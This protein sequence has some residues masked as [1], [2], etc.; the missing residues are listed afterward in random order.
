MKIN[1]K[2]YE[3]EIDYKFLDEFHNL[4]YEH[5]EDNIECYICTAFRK[6]NLDEA[7]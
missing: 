5:L 1:V 4:M 3:F 7:I 2:V 6:P